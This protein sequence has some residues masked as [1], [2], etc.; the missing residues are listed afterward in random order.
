MIGMTS[1]DANA[2]SEF[3][4]TGE[5]ARLVGLNRSTIFRAV[6]RGELSAEEFE[7]DG[8][9]YYRVPMTSLKDYQRRREEKVLTAPINQQRSQADNGKAVA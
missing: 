6:Q 3:V 8:R 4:S 2:P 1:K 7:V 5:A 9:T